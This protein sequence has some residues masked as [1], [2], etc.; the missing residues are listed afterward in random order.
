MKRLSILITTSCIVIVGSTYKTNAVMKRLQRV[1][2]HHSRSSSTPDLSSSSLE[3]PSTSNLTRPNV[4]SVSTSTPSLN[5]GGKS[6]NK[7]KKFFSSSDNKAD[8]KKEKP[9]YTF[10]DYLKGK[11]IT[12]EIYTQTP[13]QVRDVGTQYDPPNPLPDVKDAATQYDPPK[14]ST[15]SHFFGIFSKNKPKS[16]ESL[17]KDENLPKQKPSIK[18]V[19]YSEEYRQL[20][21]KQ[22][23]LIKLHQQALQK[24]LQE[25]LE[26]LSPDSDQ[27]ST[28]TS[29]RL[30]NAQVALQERN[31]K[32]AEL[33]EK[34]KDL[35]NINTEIKSISVTL[36]DIHPI[37]KDIRE[38]DLNN[39]T[40]IQ[41]KIITPKIPKTLRSS[42]EQ[43]T[44]L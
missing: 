22:L 8:N 33:E 32:L 11:P 38:Q 12:A 3:T 2:F 28:S 35:K 9:P 15:K 42:K 17:P 37:K 14:S 23:E 25:H 1:G 30:Q 13:S 19:T 16:N 43:S 7:F 6:K 31:I 41:G 36:A 40:R 29:T 39:E 20:E 4:K 34:V 5:Q 26:V 24:R 27:P 10:W 21:K 18:S 44:K